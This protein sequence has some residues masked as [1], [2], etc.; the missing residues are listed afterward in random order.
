MKTKADILKGMASYYGKVLDEKGVEIYTHMLRN[1]TL[2]HITNAATR[3]IQEQTTFPLFPVLRQYLDEEKLS[4]V[5]DQAILESNFCKVSFHNGGKP[6]FEDPITDRIMRSAM[7]WSDW[8]QRSTE[9]VAKFFQGQ[10]VKEYKKIYFS[11]I[12]RAKLKSK[13]ELEPAEKKENEHISE[14]AKRRRQ[15]VKDLEKKSGETYDRYQLHP[16]AIYEGADLGGYIINFEDELF[17]D[18]L[19]A[20]ERFKQDFPRSSAIING[21]PMD[22]WPAA[23]PRLTGRILTNEEATAML[24]PIMAKLRAINASVRT[25]KAKA[26]TSHSRDV[27]TAC[28]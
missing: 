25:P 17:L 5:E 15:W 21:V 2:E 19:K 18:K 10:F 13:K 14:H 12:E 27:Q 16:W 7:Q 20:S 23:K 8:S 11:E 22:K 4:G 26:Y 28:N 24:A 9:D 1:Y 6:H 3:A